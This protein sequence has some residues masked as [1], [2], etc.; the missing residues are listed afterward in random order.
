VKKVAATRAAK[1][2]KKSKGADVSLEAHGSMSSPDDVRG[3]PSF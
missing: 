2:L 3:Y 1:H